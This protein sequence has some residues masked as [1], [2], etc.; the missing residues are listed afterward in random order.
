MDIIIF[1]SVDSIYLP[2]LMW[3]QIKSQVSFDAKMLF[4]KFKISAK[5]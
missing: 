3:R 4:S 5:S 1:G 2:F